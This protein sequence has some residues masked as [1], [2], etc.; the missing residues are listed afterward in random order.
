MAESTK[1]YV[2]IER[3]LRDPLATELLGRALLRVLEPGHAVFLHGP[4][5]A[6]KTTLVRGALREAGYSGDVRSPTFALMVPY[7]TQPP[8]LHADFYRVS[9]AAGL[10]LE[11]YA[12][13]H[14]LW[15]EWPTPELESEYPDAI[16]VWLDFDLHGGR[17]ATLRLDPSLAQQFAAQED[18]DADL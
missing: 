10:G 8:I 2:R 11:D 15:M 3:I 12:A 4:L 14:V 13:D 17:Q 1:E 9:S 16:A 5:G 6:G 18:A 7:A